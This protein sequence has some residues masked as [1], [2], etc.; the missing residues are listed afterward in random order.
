MTDLLE[1]ILS[2]SDPAE[3]TLTAKVLRHH[4]IALAMD[5]ARIRAGFPPARFD[6][7]EID[8]PE[9]E[10]AHAAEAAARDLAVAIVQSVDPDDPILL[11]SCLSSIVLDAGAELE[12]L[13]EEPA[14]RHARDLARTTSDPLP[15]AH[16]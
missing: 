8:A 15:G 11:R 4:A 2:G 7:V 14:A 5:A 1:T 3:P 9:L 16:R 13:G 10:I 12:R 6:D